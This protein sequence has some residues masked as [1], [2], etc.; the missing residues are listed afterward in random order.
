MV[1]IFK[2]QNEK[3]EFISILFLQ[4]E[5]EFPR[6]QSFWLSSNSMSHIPSEV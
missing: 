2:Y 6:A 1:Y 4:E 5:K 3:P